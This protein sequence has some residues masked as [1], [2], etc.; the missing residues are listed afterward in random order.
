MLDGICFALYGESSGD[1]RTADQMRCDYAPKDLLTT[2][3]LVFQ[4]RQTCYRVERILPQEKQKRRGAGTTNQKHEANLYKVTGKKSELIISKKA[5]DVTHYIVDLLGLKSEQFRQVMVLPQGKFRELL[6]A[7]SKDKEVIFSQLF[8]TTIY[9]K[10]EQYLKEKAKDIDQVKKAQTQQIQGLLNSIEVDSAEDLGAKLGALQ[11]GL[12]AAE[13]AKKR[14]EA[15]QLAL[16]QQQ[17]AA[18]ALKKQFDD[19]T[20]KQVELAQKLAQAQEIEAQK[21]TLKQAQQ[22]GKIT[23]QFTRTVEEAKKTAALQK[24]LK[25]LEKELK[26]ATTTL[27]QAQ[28]QLTA[29][30]LEFAAVDDLKQEKNNL[31]ALTKKLEQ[32]TE[33]QKNLKNCEKVSKKSLT[34]LAQ[35]QEKYQALRNEEGAVSSQIKTRQSALKTLGDRQ[36]LLVTGQQQLTQRQKLADLEAEKATLT[37][38]QQTLQQTQEKLRQKFDQ[39]NHHCRETERD[40][41]L[42]QAAILAQQLEPD[43]PCPV[44]GSCEHP[45]PTTPDDRQVISDGQLKKVRKKR[46]DAQ[47]AFHEGE[48]K[49]DEVNHNLEHLTQA[50]QEIIGELVE[51]AEQP[52]TVIEAQVKTLENEVEQ[53]KTQQAEAEAFTNHQLELV[54]Q[55]EEQEAAIAKLKETQDADHTALTKA[56]TSYED[57]ESQIPTKFK[58]PKALAKRLKTLTEEIETLTENR[59]KAQSGLEEKQHQYSDLQGQQRQL[60]QQIQAQKQSQAEA[61]QAWQLALTASPFQIYKC[62][63]LS[64]YRMQTKRRSPRP[65]KPMNRKRISSRG[66]CNTYRIPVNR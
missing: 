7:K 22:A 47:T 15:E 56:R 33:R 51:I 31:E 63:K 14:A 5:T 61:D 34:A 38:E 57:L 18:I 28:E 12:E 62:F 1:E 42:G 17:E 55:I 29:A 4:F 21:I 11:P 2:L 36:I 35:H 37:A 49:V 60:T 23:P 48:K 26:A 20:N 54:K 50:I 39:A 19:L 65:L 43:Q 30:K 52:L 25:K 44:C 32:L 40:W 6:V 59:E 45:Q 27:T 13:I 58:T 41:H 10:L 53:L 24:Q 8:Q 64:S 66:L 46:D 3:E 9:D 16:T